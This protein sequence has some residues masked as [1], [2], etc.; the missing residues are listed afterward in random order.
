MQKIGTSLVDKSGNE[1]LA[2]PFVPGV[3]ILSNGDQV[4]APSLGEK[5]GDGSQL[6]ERLLQFGEKDSIDYVD[7][8]TVVTRKVHRDQVIEERSRR[9]GLGFD[10]DFGEKDPRGV[11]RIGTTDADLVGWDEVSKIAQA[12]INLG[13]S[14]TPITIVT[15]TGPAI[16]TALEWQS[17]LVAAGQYR[18][19]IWAASFALQAMDPIPQ[20]FADDKHWL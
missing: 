20:G 12:A 7:G 13:A 5:F 19:P 11:H 10:Y 6:V 16:V 9:L 17:I 15:D 14:D 2:W 3:I 18:Q 4:N 1:Q 8:K